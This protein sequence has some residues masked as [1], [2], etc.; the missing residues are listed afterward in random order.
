[1]IHRQ[2]V[3]SMLT[4]QFFTDLKTNISYLPPLCMS[5][6]THLYWSNIGPI[7]DSDTPILVQYWM[8]I[9]ADIR[10]GTRTLLGPI[11]DPNIGN[12]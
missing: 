6:Q 8:P 3:S 9:L 1:M 5:P 2:V 10:G 12:R 11:L 7:L 4:W